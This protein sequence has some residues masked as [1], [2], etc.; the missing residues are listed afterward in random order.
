[1][2]EAV[3]YTIIG[4]EPGT[5]ITD[6]TYRALEAYDQLAGWNFEESSTAGM[7]GLLDEA[8]RKEE[9]IIVTG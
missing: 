4:I 2:S 5:G 6:Q 7:L 1:M 9:P 3:E 8:I